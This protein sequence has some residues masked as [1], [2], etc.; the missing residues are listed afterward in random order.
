MS[1]S[2]LGLIAGFL[3]AIVI[4]IGGWT[5]FLLALVLGLVGL[6]I[7]AQLDGAVDIGDLFRGRNG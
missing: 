4:L 3:L 2:A 1:K 7:G 6:A 5:G